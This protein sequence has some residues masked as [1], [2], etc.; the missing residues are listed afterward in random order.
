M[1]DY[2]EAEAIKKLVGEASTILIIQ[3]DNPDGDSLGSALAL[4]QILGDMG[5]QPVLY[6]AVTIPTYLRYL[7]GWDRVQTEL[8]SKFDLSIIVDCSSLSLLESLDKA[9]QLGRLS[10]VPCLILDHH[11]V[12]SDIPFASLS[13]NHKAVATGEL[14]YELATQLKWEMNLGAKEM[15]AS[16]ILSDSLGLMT[17]ATTA[18]SISIIAELVADGV[19]LTEIDDA[20]RELMRKSPEILAYKG[21]LLQRIEYFDDNKIATITIPWAEIEKY[22]HTYNPSMLVID[23]MR[24]SEQTDVA[25]AFKQYP[26]GRITAKI[27]ANYGKPIAAKLAQ[28]FGGNGHDYA[29]GFKIDAKAHKDFNDIKNDCIAEASQLLAKIR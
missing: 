29:S 18:R 23:D 19:K 22:S 16:S 26:D 9:N 20:R 11:Q 6:C 3:A 21:R 12:K 17:E 14:I 2:P 7:S 10:K 8:P 15:I 1:S 28:H 13:C 25:I 24:M 4:E 27:R 5:K